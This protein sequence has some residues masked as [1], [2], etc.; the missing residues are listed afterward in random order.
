[1]AK[2]DRLGIRRTLLLLLADHGVL[3]A[4]IEERIKREQLTEWVACS[5]AESVRADVLPLPPP[6]TRATM[7]PA[8][9]S[10]ATG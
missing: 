10:T 1:M 2:H 3:R 9:E 5:E 7:P 6:A 8:D 4:R